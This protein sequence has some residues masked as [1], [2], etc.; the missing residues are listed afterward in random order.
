MVDK[1]YGNVI[2]FATTID[3]IYGALCIFTK[4]IYH[5]FYEY[6][7]MKTPFAPV[8][9]LL[10]LER[11]FES[12]C[13]CWLNKSTTAPQRPKKNWKSGFLRVN[14]YQRRPKWLC[15][16]S[17]NL[18]ATVYWEARCVIYIDLNRFNVNLKIKWPCDD[19]KVVFIRIYGCTRVFAMAKIHYLS[20]RILPHPAYFPD[21][22][23]YDHFL[24]PN[25]KNPYYWAV[26]GLGPSW[27]R[28]N[29]RLFS[30]SE[31]M[32]S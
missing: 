31:N 30:K 29:K 3:G 22:A 4:R 28:W 13:I 16:E 7:G 8:P 32:L 15:T 5:N 26:R 6:L 12:F 2:W 17:Q 1:I 24:F 11:A 27:N 10:T 18:M 20:Y 25:P 19:K 23:L 14:F 9:R 21:L